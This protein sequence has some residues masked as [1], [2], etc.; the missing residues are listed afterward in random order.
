MARTPLAGESVSRSYRVTCTNTPRGLLVAPVA[1]SRTSP[2]EEPA[3]KAAPSTHT[4][5]VDGAVPDAGDVLSQGA[6]VVAVHLRVPPPVL[7]MVT[8]PSE[9]HPRVLYCLAG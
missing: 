6:L 9:G 8:D 1:E 3:G 2:E 7:L 5:T 4:L